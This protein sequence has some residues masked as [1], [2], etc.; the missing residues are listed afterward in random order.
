[1]K[2]VVVSDIHSDV[3][4][5]L[6]YLD[7]IKEIGF[8]V[9]VCPGDF[10]DVNVPKG[11][12]QEDVVKLIINEL[13]SLKVPVMTVPGNVDPKNI[14]KILEKDGVSIHGRGV[15]VG[16]YGFFGYGGAKTPFETSIEPTEEELKTGLQKAYKDIRE[17]KFKVLVTH[18]PPFGT[19]LDTIQSGS[20]VGSKAVRAFIEKYQPVL[21]ISAH[22]HEARG[23]DR[24]KNSFLINSGRFPE[25]YYGH[26]EITNSSVDGKVLNISE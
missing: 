2:I 20:H 13:K 18:N 14:I 26:V 22:I 6:G 23:I 3:E 7:K 17:A 5:L 9:I 11:F 25:G 8:D 16:D 4:N 1:M 15:R 19:R 21:S 10:T 24:L 12:T